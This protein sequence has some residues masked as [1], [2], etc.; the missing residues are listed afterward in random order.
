MVLLVALPTTT[1]W[2][3]SAPA[4]CSRVSSVWVFSRKLA[5]L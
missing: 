4:A 5:S 3:G 1:T 2:L